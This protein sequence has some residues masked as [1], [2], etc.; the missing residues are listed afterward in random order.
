MAHMIPKNNPCKSIAPTAQPKQRLQGLLPDAVL[1]EDANARSA[2]GTVN[3]P[4][5]KTHPFRPATPQKGT[6]QG[7]TFLSFEFRANNTRTLS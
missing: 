6:R 5:N 2:G 1:D 4:P 3:L 7:Y